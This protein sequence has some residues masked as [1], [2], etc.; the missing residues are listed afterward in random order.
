MSSDVVAPWAFNLAPAPCGCIVPI[1]VSGKASPSIQTSGGQKDIVRWKLVKCPK[2]PL[3]VRLLPS[4][5][6][7][8]GKLLLSRRLKLIPHF[9]FPKL[10]LLEAQ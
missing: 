8:R 6:I 5:S 2:E 1:Y 9:L 3:K 7:F 4:D 10:L